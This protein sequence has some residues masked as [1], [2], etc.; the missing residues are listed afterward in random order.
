MT[1]VSFVFDD[2]FLSSC[3]KTAKIF[4]SRGLRADFAVLVDPAGFTPDFPKG[5][6][7]LWNE[8]Q[9]RGHAIYPHGY[10]HT[11]LSQIPHE[12][13]VAK[14][15]ACLHVFEEKLSGFVTSRSI[16]HFTYNR[17]TPALES[18][19]LKKVGAIRTN[20]DGNVNEEMNSMKDI[21]NRI[22]SCIWHGPDPCNAHLIE[23]LGRAELK[24]PYLL[25]YMLH[26]LDGEGWGPLDSDILE[27][28][29]DIILQSDSMTYTN[30]AGLLTK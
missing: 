21:V 30:L 2:G 24:Q 14:I 17:S 15:D 7:D 26:G 27:K 6:F 16:Y 19:L 18:Y 5:D 11:D 1:K 10:D 20:Q 8:L 22:F 28:V 29:L 9:A 4:E 12:E 3:L 23:T 13:A 25:M